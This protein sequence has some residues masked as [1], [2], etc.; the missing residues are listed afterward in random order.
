MILTSAEL[1]GL[2]ALFSIF[3]TRLNRSIIRPADI[4]AELILGAYASACPNIQDPKINASETL[5]IL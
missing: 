1:K 2:G 4:T 3:G 5:K